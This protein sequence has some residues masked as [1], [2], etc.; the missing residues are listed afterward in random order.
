[1]LAFRVGRLP[2]IRSPTEPP[3]QSPAPS[4]QRIW[5]KTTGGRALAFWMIAPSLLLAPLSNSPPPLFGEGV[6]SK[7]G[8]SPAAS[9]P[10]LGPACPQ[11][12]VTPVPR[13]LGWLQGAWLD[14]SALYFRVLSLSGQA[15]SDSPLCLIRMHS[16]FGEEE[17]NG[18]ISS[19]EGWSKL[20]VTNR[21]LPSL[22]GMST[23]ST[24]L[25]LQPEM[26]AGH[27]AQLWGLPQRP[28]GSWRGL[29]QHLWPPKSK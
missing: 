14:K 5:D 25:G 8:P 21:S 26:V 29:S 4:K 11:L 28:P 16:S 12:G 20:S 2:S 15:A 17:R 24:A 13:S 9:S 10:R 23:G 3:C 1:M 7:A 27:M 18:Y 19:F 6:G 22:L